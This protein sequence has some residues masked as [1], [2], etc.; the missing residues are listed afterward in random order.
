VN[1]KDPKNSILSDICNSA[2]KNKKRNLNQDCQ[3][4]LQ[5]HNIR[6]YIKTLAKPL[7]DIPTLVAVNHYCRPLVRRK[8]LFT[9]LDSIITTSLATVAH[10]KV[11]KRQI[12]WVAKNDLKTNILFFSVKVRKVQLAVIKVYDLL[13]VG[14]HYPFNNKNKWVYFLKNGCDI[15]FYPEAVIGTKMRPAKANFQDMLYFLKQQNI[16]FQVLPVTIYQK[17]GTFYVV[18]TKTIKS[19]QNAD[20]IASQ[21]MLTLAGSLPKN[22]R[23]YYEKAVSSSA[24]TGR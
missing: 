5:L 4:F 2:I 22:L 18:I 11:S 20:E 8:S 13:S 21:T 19:S 10:S 12:T 1:L 16:K 14:K 7:E 15:G 24:T 6:Y 17:G 9:T 23:G 3:D